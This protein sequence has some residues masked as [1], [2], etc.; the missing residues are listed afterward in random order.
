MGASGLF[1]PERITTIT[2]V[3]W[4]HTG[5]LGFFRYWPMGRDQESVQHED[6]WN[7]AVVGDNDFMHHKVERTGPR[8]MKPP[9]EMTMD[10]FLDHDGDDWIIV[11]DGRTLDRYGD[12]HV[13]LSLSWRAKVVERDTSAD[14]I[15]LD[16]V[17]A[18]FAD[19]VGDDFAA[20][21]TDEL[22]TEAA[23]DQL[24][25]RWPGFRPD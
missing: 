14:P 3:A 9:A 2:A 20:S 1:E 23:R 13:R 12:E 25:A 17:L 18:R 19:Q 5:E 7:T 15:T 16:D 22:F 11:E 24:V 8:D 4:F 6:M 21:S 10:T